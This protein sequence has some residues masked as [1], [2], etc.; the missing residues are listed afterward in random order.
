MGIQGQG[1]GRGGGS[2]DSSGIIN[3]LRLV[4]VERLLGVERKFLDMSQG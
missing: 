2:E 1:Q 3:K 4:R